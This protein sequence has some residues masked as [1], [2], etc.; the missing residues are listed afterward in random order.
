MPSGYRWSYVTS[1]GL[2]QNTRTVLAGG[3]PLVGEVV[4]GVVGD[5][6]GGVAGDVLG[7]VAGPLVETP[8]VQV[9]PFSVKL[10]GAGLEPV[11]AP[12]KPKLAVPLVAIVPL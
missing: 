8:P 12:L 10:V 6:L 3:G 5:V 7:G 1:V 11:Q 9:T 4:G 2:S